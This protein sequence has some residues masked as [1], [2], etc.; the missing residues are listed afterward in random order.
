MYIFRHECDHSELSSQ[1]QKLFKKLLVENVDAE[2]GVVSRGRKYKF[3][4]SAF[5]EPVDVLRKRSI[6]TVLPD[7]EATK[8]SLEEAEAQKYE[9]ILRD[10]TFA[11][12]STLLDDLLVDTWAALDEVITR[13]EKKFR[14]E[15]LYGLAHPPPGPEG[16]IAGS[17]A[18]PPPYGTVE[19]TEWP[20]L[21]EA[22][23]QQVAAPVQDADA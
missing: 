15:E 20:P 14:I 9:A 12:I 3:R 16:E 6:P 1:S 23:R 17:E 5:N 2:A 21:R 19:P 22:L 8:K 11:Y 4:T 18:P 7:A 13:E 10:Q